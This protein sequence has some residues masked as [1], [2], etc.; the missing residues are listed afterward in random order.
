MK[1]NKTMKNAKRCTT[2]GFK[3]NAST[4]FI[5]DYCKK[6]LFMLTNIVSK[7]MFV[8]KTPLEQIIIFVINIGKMRLACIISL[9]ADEIY[10]K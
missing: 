6:S 8:G 1:W 9:I 10:L 2:F 5:E 7:E 4:F 3:V